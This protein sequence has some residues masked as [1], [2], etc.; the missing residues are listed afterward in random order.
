MFA[1]I[2]LKG[3]QELAQ[4]FK[5]RSIDKYY[6]T[7]VSGSFDKSVECKGYISRDEGTLKS[8]V[9]SDEEFALK[10]IGKTAKTDAD[11]EKYVRIETYFEPI[12]VASDYSLLR[13]KLV[14]GKTHQIRA[15]LAMLGFPIIGDSKYGD[16]RVNAYMRERYGL[17]NQLL[18]AGDAIWVE[19]GISVH[20]KL[21]D[22]F[23]KICKGEGLRWQPGTQEV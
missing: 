9:I 8:T 17:K 22:G 16:R 1:G 19:K 2:S 14:T 10:N 23:I 6:Y 5:N 3:S 7:I 11:E 20:A 15:H 18:H 13:I 4:A 21:P 12:S